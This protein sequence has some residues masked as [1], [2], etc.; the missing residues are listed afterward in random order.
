MELVEI[1]EAVQTVKDIVDIINENTSSGSEAIPQEVVEV[2]QSFG[3]GERGNNDI[4]V[5]LSDIKS[6]LISDYVVSDDETYELTISQR[7]DI[8]DKRL[9]SEFITLN[10]C[11]GLIATC[12]LSFFAFKILTWLYDSISR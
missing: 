1:W 5:L 2:L 8:I 4:E 9:D 7:L 12:F 6:S 11:F 10:D 3:D